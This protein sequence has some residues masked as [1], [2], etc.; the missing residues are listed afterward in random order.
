M[1][2]WSSLSRQLRTLVSHNQGSGGFEEW[3]WQPRDS[4]CGG[5]FRLLARGTA[6]A[7]PTG[8]S[9]ALKTRPDILFLIPV[10]DQGGLGH[11]RTVVYRRFTAR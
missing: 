4:R 3:S 7:S 9:S 10:S 11:G 6:V 2:G 1:N 8:L 5:G